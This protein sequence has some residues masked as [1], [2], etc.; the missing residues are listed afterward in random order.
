MG[1][2]G[3]TRVCKGKKPYSIDF[4]QIYAIMNLKNVQ[5]LCVLMNKGGV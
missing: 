3:I 1:V 4:Q 5:Y 2:N